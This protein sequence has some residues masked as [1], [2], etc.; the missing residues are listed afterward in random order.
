MTGE[1]LKKAIR[2]SGWKQKDVAEV[3]GM[4]KQ[5]FNARFAT[6]K[7]DSEFV[8]KVM[9]IISRPYGYVSV[10]GDATNSNINSVTLDHEVVAVFREQL[11]TKDEQIKTLLDIIKAG[12]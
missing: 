1:E 10:G 3:L 8:E 11:Q 9:D 4:S 7:I 6:Q 2:K 12:K 5:N